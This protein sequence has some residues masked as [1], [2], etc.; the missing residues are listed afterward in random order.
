MLEAFYLPRENVVYC[1]RAIIDNLA[2][3]VVSVS[4]PV[5]TA[6]ALEVLQ[7]LWFWEGTLVELVTAVEEPNKAV[8]IEC[9]NRIMD[10]AEE[11]VIR[12]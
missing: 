6:L 9:G 2:N 7:S 10:V 4:S 3:L 11:G 8:P 1:L 5:Q 12:K